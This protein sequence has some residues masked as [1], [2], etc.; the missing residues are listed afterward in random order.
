MLLVGEECVGG[1]R[2]VGTVPVVFEC[3]RALLEYLFTSLWANDVVSK[4]EILM[5]KE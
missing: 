2:V 5:E 3:F 1:E 4:A